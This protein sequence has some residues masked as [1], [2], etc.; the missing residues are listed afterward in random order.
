MKIAIL[1]YGL[2]GESAYNYWNTP[3]NEITVCDQNKSLILPDDVRRVLGPDHLKNLDQYDLIVR[4]PVVHERDIVSNNA[5][6]I[7]RKV[8]TVTNEFMKGC[9]KKNI[10]LLTYQANEDSRERR[11]RYAM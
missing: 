3:E 1:G 7:L 8:T 9:L 4:S 10:Y 5:P 11:S 2:Q 6:E